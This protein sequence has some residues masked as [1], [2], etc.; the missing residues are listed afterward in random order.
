MRHSQIAA[1]HHHQSQKIHTIADNDIIVISTLP[2]T[3]QLHTLLPITLTISPGK[4]G[5]LA[6]DLTNIVPNTTVS[7]SILFVSFS[8]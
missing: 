7:D 4:G 1:I 2:T 3:S 5:V 6:L 8:Y